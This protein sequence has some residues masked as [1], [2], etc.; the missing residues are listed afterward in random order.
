MFVIESNGLWGHHIR[1]ATL[2]KE[3]SWN[4]TAETVI[5]APLAG[6]DLPAPIAPL[7]PFKD[8][9]SIVL[10]LSGKHIYPVHGAGCGALNNCAT[11][12]PGTR[13]THAQTI[14][15]AL[16]GNST[17][18]YPVL[19]L[20]VHPRAGEVF[21]NN[22]SLIAP[23]RP[24]PLIA[25]PEVAFR[26]LFGSVAG[27]DARKMFDA[28]A[29]LLDHIRGDVRR[30]RDAL[31]AMDREKLDI[32]LESFNQMRDRQDKIGGMG[33]QLRAHLPN[34]AGLEAKRATD[35]F[36]AQCAVA[37]SAL[38]ARLTNVVVIDTVCYFAGYHHRTDLGVKIEG[39]AI[40]HLHGDPSREEHGVPVRR[41]HAERVADI[42]GRLAAVKEGD[43]TLLD[44]TLI[45]WMSDAAEEHHGTGQ[46]WPLVLV[47]N[48]GGRLK[49]AGRFLQYPGYGKPGHRTLG[50]FYLA[51][52]RAFGDERKTFGE[53]DRGL[54]GID[55]AG[56]L[57]EILA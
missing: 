26:T 35:R 19:G 1:P 27:G 30:V 49:T 32:Y 36:K 20:A 22:A 31:P 39:H 33:D 54:A 18:P 6:H 43:G 40:G 12:V 48:L 10:G 21:V 15:H 13:P 52:L 56:P 11:A 45:V 55:T 53:V 47:S 17:L 44:N 4:S 37:A 5:D 57:A 46:Q 7:E 38:A 3:S 41:F 42:A 25:D 28:R 14:D 29:K 9:M 16:A 51:L 23:R 2:G 50:N 8:R 24:L 34:M